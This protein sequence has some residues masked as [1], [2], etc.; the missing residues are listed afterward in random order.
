MCLSDPSRCGSMSDRHH[1]PRRALYTQS[2]AEVARIRA[3]AEAEMEAIKQEGRRRLDE[4]TS[5]LRG[6]LVAAEEALQVCSFP[7]VLLD[8]RTVGGA[9]SRTPLDQFSNL[10]YF[11]PSIHHFITVPNNTFQ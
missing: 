8:V 3:A 5:G 6:K 11:A 1:R 9:K 10:G 2:Q 4:C 7:T